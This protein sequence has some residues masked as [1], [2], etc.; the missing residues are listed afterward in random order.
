MRFRKS[1][2]H[3][4]LH[5][6][7][8]RSANIDMSGNN[9]REITIMADTSIYRDIAER[10]SNTFYLG[11][12]G[13]VRTGKSTFIKKFMEALVIPNIRDEHERERARDEMPQSAA[14][15]TVMTTEPKFIPDEAVEITLSD[16]AVMK[17][18]MVDCVGYIVPDAIGHIEDGH[19]RMVHT[20]WQAE[21]MPF[22]KAAEL[23]T[24]KV[25]SE[26][27]TV[28][29]LITTDGTI[30][31]IP[32]SSY[33]EAEER[34]ARELSEAGKPFAIILNSA[35]PESEAALKLALELEGNYAAPVALVNCL[36]LDGDDIRHILELV[37]MEF[38]V[39]EVK[40]KLPDW[41]NALEPAH[42]MRRALD[43]FILER[44]G[45]VRKIGEISGVF[46]EVCENEFVKGLRID[47]I[48]LGKGTASISAELHD[49]LYY[50]V[51]SELCGFDIS[52]EEKL[53]TLL[54]ELAV[55]KEKYDRVADALNDVTE[56]GY[57][58]VM[59]EIEDLHLEEPEIVKQA[60]GYGV[61]LR[62]SA[63]SIHMIKADIETEIS[64][65]VGTEQQSEEVVKYMLREFE[66]DPKKIW[67]SNMFGKTLH[68]LVNEGLHTKLEHMPEDARSKL[69]ETL[70]RIINEG[71]GGLIC[72]IL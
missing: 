19:D 7:F 37:L 54:R 71:S 61:R 48:D 12:V 68:Q 11:V 8:V 25:I 42:Y 4:R 55:M 50:K 65:V 15:K 29:M 23:G 57:G 1:E 20:P 60:G 53:I 41:I 2:A 46:T 49:G 70:G 39:S 40:V 9:R 27:S 38:P 34:V 18:K 59:P 13:P 14:G 51:I 35:E 31:E 21:P 16:N 36:R 66:E 67:G 44:A 58:I 72:I 22:A 5:E 47:R 3:F 56:K 6:Y 32:R 64:P 24:R 26:H 28:G 69:S 52:N 10:C 63:P 17:V 30:G 33:V 45:R 62:A 43:E